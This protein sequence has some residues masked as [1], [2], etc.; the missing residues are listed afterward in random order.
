M[1]KS[2]LILSIVLIVSTQA[3]FLSKNRANNDNEINSQFKFSPVKCLQGLS[4][5]PKLFLDFKEAFA[6]RNNNT[7]TVVTSFFSLADELL[8]GVAP[9]CGNNATA[10]QI[11]AYFPQECADATE[12]LALYAADFRLNNRSTA[13]IIS[14]I[15]ELYVDIVALQYSCPTLPE[16]KYN[17]TVVECLTQTAQFPA[18][19][20]NFQTA[21]TNRTQV[22]AQVVNTLADIVG[23]LLYKWVP[24]C[25]GDE[26]EAQIQE[27]LPPTCAQNVQTLTLLVVDLVQHDSNIA[28]IVATLPTLYRDSLAVYNNCPE[29][30]TT[31]TVYY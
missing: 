23:E 25:L 29:F 30:N 19:I 31:S 26:I 6:N 13:F 24:A 27:Y 2:L 5:V 20:D 18:L 3:S 4:L 21:W 10:T 1:Q 9:A 8:Y 17:S 14:K 15:A 16:P 11:N 22:P 28:Y 12:T 7:R